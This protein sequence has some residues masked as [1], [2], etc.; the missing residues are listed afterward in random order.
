MTPSVPSFSLFAEEAS[1]ASCAIPPFF[2]VSTV[3]SGETELS[4]KASREPISINELSTEEAEAD[5]VSW[6]SFVTPCGR[7]DASF[8]ASVSWTSCVTPS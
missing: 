3:F 7:E 2:P 1:G 8:K 5:A 4:F 6:I